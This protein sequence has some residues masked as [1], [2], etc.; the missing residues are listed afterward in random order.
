MKTKGLFRKTSGRIQTK[1]PDQIWTDGIR[2]AK[3]YAQIRSGASDGDR[4]AA[5]SWGRENAGGEP[6]AGGAVAER[7]GGSPERG[8]S[9]A[10]VHR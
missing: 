8:R 10:R 6:D 4:T 7:G 3:G 5:V 1:P 9:G 2:W